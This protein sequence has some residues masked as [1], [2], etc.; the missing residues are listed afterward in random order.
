MVFREPTP[1][2]KADGINFPQFKP[3]Q[4]LTGPWALG[5]DPQWGGPPTAE[6]NPLV[7]WTQRPEDGIKFYSG[8]ATYRKTFDHSLGTPVNHPATSRLVLDLDAVRDLANVR[9]NGRNLGIVWTAPWQLDIT[10]AVKPGTNALEIRVT[11]LWPNRL[12]GDLA[13][14]VEQRLTSTNITADRIPAL[15]SSGL[16]GPVRIVTD[17]TPQAGYR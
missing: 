11:N 8:T 7:S 1:L 3:L 17:L 4:E 12:R 6:F 15:L 9:L 2:T 16:L 10:D 5:F 13:R 14:P